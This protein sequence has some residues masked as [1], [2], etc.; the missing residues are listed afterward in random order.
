[1]TTKTLA[2]MQVKDVMT[3][4]PVCAAPSMTAFEL[5]EL[6]EGNEISGVPVVDA[7]ERVVGVVSRTDLIHRCIDAPM[8]GAPG[9]L[10]EALAENFGEAGG[11]GA[12]GAVDADTLGTVEEFMTT[13]AVTATEDEPISA[14]AHRMARERVHRVIVVDGTMRPTGIVTTLD[15][16]K[17]SPAA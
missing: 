3:R 11:A 4:N 13:E 14:V 1:M 16:L 2:Q 5:A 15:L 6:L 7:H 12:G 8:G 17:L 10:L 9:G